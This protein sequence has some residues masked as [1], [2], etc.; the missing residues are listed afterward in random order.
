MRH[1]AELDNHYVPAKSAKAR[2]LKRFIQKVHWIGSEKSQEKKKG[3]GLKSVTG[4]LCA[5]EFTRT[6][7]LLWGKLPFE[8]CRRVHLGE[9]TALEKL[10]AMQNQDES[11]KDK[12]KQT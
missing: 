3:S 12:K 6:F 8:K 5:L 2:R 11:D 10:L 4:K 7:G 1:C 9:I